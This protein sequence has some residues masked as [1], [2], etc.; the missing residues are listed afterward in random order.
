M[1]TSFVVVPNYEQFAMREHLNKLWHMQALKYCS[2]II[3]IKGN[4]DM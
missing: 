3:I 2:V 1:A 4:T